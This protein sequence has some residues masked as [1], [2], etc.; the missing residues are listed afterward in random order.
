MGLSV[1]WTDFAKS[2]LRS[3][4]DYHKQ[5]V[6]TKI[7]LQISKQIFVKAENLSDFPTIGTIEEHLKDRPQGFRYIVNTNYKIIYW[8]N[9][10]KMQNRNI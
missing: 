2:Q 6:S 10:E 8:L 9:S 1:Y 5:K 3:I 4:F 7:A